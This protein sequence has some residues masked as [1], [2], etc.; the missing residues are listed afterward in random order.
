IRKLAGGT[1]GNRRRALLV[2]VDADDFVYSFQFGRSVERRC[3]ERGLYVDRVAIDPAWRRD[4]VAE[5]GGPIPA[6]VADGTEFLVQWEDDP[7]LAA[8]L[9]QLATRRY[10]VVVANVRPKLFYDLVATGLLAA[11]TLVWDRHLHDGLAEERARRGV[12][13]N[14]IRK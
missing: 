3:V 4:L 5:L 8:A 13:A 6:A 11:R 10:E 12:E 9:R 2:N 1:S 14:S 7:S